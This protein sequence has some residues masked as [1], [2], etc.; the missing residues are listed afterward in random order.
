VQNY[1]G[2]IVVRVLLGV[3]EAGFFPAATF[4]VS[5]WYCRFEVQT[6][7]AIFCC[8]ASLAGAFSGL[9]AFGISKMDGIGNIAGWRWIFILEGAI[10]ILTGIAVLFFLPDSIERSSWLSHEEKGFLR[11]RL[12]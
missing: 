11:Q 2:L 8:A 12:Q 7:I 5:T 10:T 9:L 6:R 1:N 3:S 4:L